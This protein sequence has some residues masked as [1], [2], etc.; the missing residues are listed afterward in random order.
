MVLNAASVDW[1]VRAILV[2]E[3]YEAT[4]NSNRD[5]Y[6]KF[7]EFALREIRGRGFT[8]TGHRHISFSEVPSIVVQL[9]HAVETQDLVRYREHI[10]ELLAVQPLFTIWNRLCKKRAFRPRKSKSHS[11]HADMET[12]A[13]VESKLGYESGAESGSETEIEPEYS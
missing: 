10:L 6:D 13:E 11:A 9:C 4:R 8:P 2:N 7:K 12:E 1:K 3:L 5:V